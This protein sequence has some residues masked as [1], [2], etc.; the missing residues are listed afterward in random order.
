MD[1]E[2]LY[3]RFGTEEQCLDYLF[4]LRWENGYRCPKCQHNEMWE[5]RSHKY[6]CKKCGYQTTVIAGTLFQDTHIPMTTWFHAAWYFSAHSQDITVA[7]L[8]EE[9]H[10]NNRETAYQIYRKLHRALARPNLCK[11]KGNIEAAVYEWENN[12]PKGIIAV[13]EVKKGRLGLVYLKEFNYT[14]IYI[15]DF[16][17]S[18]VEPGSK[19]K[20]IYKDDV[21]NPKNVDMARLKRLGYICDITS[22]NYPAHFTYADI[23]SHTVPITYEAAVRT[24]HKLDASKPLKEQLDI[25]CMVVSGA[26]LP[27]TFEELLTNAIHIPP[28]P[29]K[30]H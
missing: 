5:I 20:F 26:K 18:V 9:L 29:Y 25:Y 12:P 10:I 15:N 6:K 7:M 28:C 19:I 1:K 8:E 2:A 11:L 13:G 3:M 30:H 17:E 21:G 4:H 23:K 14:P 22:E 16:I 24:Y 27:I